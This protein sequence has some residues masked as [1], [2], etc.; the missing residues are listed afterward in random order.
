MLGTAMI[1]GS[2]LALS[3]AKRGPGTPPPDAEISRGDP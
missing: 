2:V 3:L 1:V